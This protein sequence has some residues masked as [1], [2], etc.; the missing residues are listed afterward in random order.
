MSRPQDISST[1][2]Q[3]EK[4]N[5]TS[6]NDGAVE[7]IL[8]TVVRESGEL[9]SHFE[10]LNGAENDN[11]YDTQ[12]KKFF[13][14]A[15]GLV[16]V[17]AAILGYTNY[18][19]SG[20][21]IGRVG[22][23]A[24]RGVGAL[25]LSKLG[26]HYLRKPGMGNKSVGTALLA[27]GAAISAVTGADIA[28]DLTGAE[29]DT[30]R[31]AA[32][33]AAL[34]KQELLQ[35]QM[36]GIDKDVTALNDRISATERGLAE[37]RD[38]LADGKVGND[39]LANKLFA[40]LTQDRQQLIEERTS[41]FAQKKALQVKWDALLETG[42]QIKAPD[43]STQTLLESLYENRDAY[44]L[45]LAFAVIGPTAA[46]GFEV[47]RE[48]AAKKAGAEDYIYGLKKANEAPHGYFGIDPR[49]LRK[50][51]DLQSKKLLT[52]LVASLKSPEVRRNSVIQLARLMADNSD[53][54]EKERYMKAISYL[55]TEEGLR[56]IEES[57]RPILEGLE[58]SENGG[59][60]GLKRNGPI[61]L[62]I[63]TPA[64]NTQPA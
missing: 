14:L 59:R 49:E 63:G 40:E 4:F 60:P 64:A 31:E 53:R 18:S 23:H 50:L 45:G 26:I 28:A 39:K 16:A 2:L 48:H 47:S 62:G 46:L 1:A 3:P 34:R 6:T 25:V 56:R 38:A 32:E 58:L 41:L 7:E 12:G 20:A 51:P 22:M 35:T 15:C 37:Q 55:Q 44:S 13:L 5:A 43:T 27:S 52:H 36:D 61:S 30:L 54:R 24:A 8:S 11:Y 9:L 10:R 33:Q 57:F 29:A 19:S 42:A 17:E 21:D